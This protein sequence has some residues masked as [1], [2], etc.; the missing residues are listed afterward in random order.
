MRVRREGRTVY[1][2]IESREDL[3]GISRYLSEAESL[4]IAVRVS[5]DIIDAGDRLRYQATL[6][7]ARDDI[8]P[9]VRI[10]FSHSYAIVYR[11]RNSTVS[12]TRVIH[13]A[14]D[15]ATILRRTL[16]SST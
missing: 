9:G 16:N 11:V 7:R 2:A 8:Y 6:W 14:R 5:G 1:W 12:I 13:G 10:V 4:D 15:I 3:R